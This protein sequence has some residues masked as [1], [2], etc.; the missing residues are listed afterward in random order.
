[1]VPCL[2][3]EKS[4]APTISSGNAKRLR[5]IPIPDRQPSLRGPPLFFIPGGARSL[6]VPRTRGMDVSSPNRTCTFQR[7]RLSISVLYGKRNVLIG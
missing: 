3:S 4:V 1:M 2:S 7:I 5:D 6:G